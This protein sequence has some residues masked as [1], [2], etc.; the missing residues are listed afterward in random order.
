MATLTIRN[1]D[2]RVYER[3]KERARASKRSLEAEA[4]TILE[5][6]AFPDRAE[7]VRRI[8]AIRAKFEGK[9]RGDVV[10]DIRED[11]DR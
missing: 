4:R 3:L 5:G 11:R 7:F 2:P 9:Y 8:N 1:L 6:A 10:A